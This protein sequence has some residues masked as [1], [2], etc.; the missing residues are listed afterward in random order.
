MGCLPPSPKVAGTSDTTIWEGDPLNRTETIYTLLCNDGIR[1]NRGVFHLLARRER[2]G[3][4][5][6]NLFS[7]R[8]LLCWTSLVLSLLFFITGAL[9]KTEYA[10]PGSSATR[11]FYAL[12]QFFFNIG[13]NTVVFV[14]AAEIFPTPFR[15]THLVRRS[16]RFG[17]AGAMLIRQFVQMAAAW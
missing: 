11:V 5:L 3:P 2:H 8:R 12:A 6:I 10:T 14:L 16:R 15:G 13:P 7:R 1:G 17:K 4:P 9:F